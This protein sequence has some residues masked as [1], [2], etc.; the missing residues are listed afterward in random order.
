MD[1]GSAGASTRAPLVKP[2]VNEPGSRKGLCLLVMRELETRET[3]SE[4]CQREV[5]AYYRISKRPT[6]SREGSS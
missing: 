6:V 3:N 4:R 2:E 1:L 5:A